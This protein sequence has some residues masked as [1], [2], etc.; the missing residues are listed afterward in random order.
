M[1]TMCVDGLAD[2]HYFYYLNYYMSKWHKNEERFMPHCH[3]TG[4]SVIVWGAIFFYLS[5]NVVVL[6]ERQYSTKHP[7]LFEQ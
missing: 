1:L 3:L 2:F 4:G 7:N 6:K 5:M